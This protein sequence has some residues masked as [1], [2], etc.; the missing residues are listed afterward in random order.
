MN[1]NGGWFLEKLNK[2]DKPLAKQ[3]RGNRDRSKLRKSGM[4][5]RHNNRN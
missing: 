2:I 3:A 1:K 4:N 5:S